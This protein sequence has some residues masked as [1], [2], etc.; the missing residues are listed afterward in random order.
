MKQI[1]YRVDNERI[2]NKLPDF[3]ENLGKKVSKN[4]FALNCGGC[5]VYSSLVGEKIKAFFPFIWVRLRVANKNINKMR[6]INS[7]KKELKINNEMP[8]VDDWNAVGVYF[9]HIVLE[10]KYK[11]RKLLCDSNMVIPYTNT[12]NYGEGVYQIFGGY[13]TLKE[14]LEL[15]QDNNGWNW[16]FDRGQIPKLKRIIKKEFESFVKK[17]IRGGELK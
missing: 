2:M 15:A 13:L 4:I 9:E 17:L 6:N 14:G 12:L 3:L 10:I 5:C 11:K 16:T 1:I 8:N 7:F